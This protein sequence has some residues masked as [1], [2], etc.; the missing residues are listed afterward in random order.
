MNDLED[1]QKMLAVQLRGYLLS[2]SGWDTLD[3]YT[4]GREDPLSYSY[5]ILPV[6]FDAVKEILSHLTEL[7]PLSSYDYIK[8]EQ[9]YMYCWGRIP[10]GYPV[11]SDIYLV[12]SKNRDIIYLIRWYTA[13]FEKKMLRIEKQEEG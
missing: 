3:H 1:I 12:R 10:T 11:L 13:L 9:G 5:K 2:N 6:S 4:L 7:G 8:D